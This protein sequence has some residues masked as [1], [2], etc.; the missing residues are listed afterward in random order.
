MTT[1][2]ELYGGYNEQGDHEV[3]PDCG[4]CLI[5]DSCMCEYLKENPDLRFPYTR[6]DDGKGLK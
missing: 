1:M 3:C 6:N 4:W 2:N 5:C